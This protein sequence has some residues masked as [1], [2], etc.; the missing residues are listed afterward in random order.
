MLRTDNGDEDKDTFLVDEMAEINNRK[1]E[2][3]SRFEVPR[4]IQE[5]SK[6]TYYDEN[7]TH[8]IE[9]IQKVMTIADKIAS[10]K[11][12]DRNLKEILI[13]SA[14]FHDSGRGKDKDGNDAH[15]IASAMT[16]Q[17]YYEENPD[18]PF[19]I[20]ESNLPI[21]QTLIEYHEINDKDKSKAHAKLRKIG[22]KYGLD[23]KGNKFNELVLLAD[24]LK[25]ADALDRYRFHTRAKLNPEYLRFEESKGLMP[26]A[27]NINKKFAGKVL[28]DIYHATPEALKGHSKIGS[29]EYFRRQTAISNPDYIEPHIDVDE[30]LEL[31]R[32]EVPQPKS[33][34]EQNLTKDDKIVFKRDS[35]DFCLY[36]D[37]TPQDVKEFVL[38]LT[39][40]SQQ[41]RENNIDRDGN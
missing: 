18:N 26:F 20:N 24:A 16:V 19:N 31:Y 36:D 29:L 38:Q 10:A 13:I 39:R 6:T 23:V 22:L 5:I 8:S 12:F 3:F 9:H 21:I 32:Y 40:T 35:R 15:G 14:A 28:Q 27:E 4:L 7:K 25:D 11:N 37:L 17:K 41:F 33:E 30:L 2:E 1:S 34:E